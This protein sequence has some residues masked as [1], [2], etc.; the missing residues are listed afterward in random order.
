MTTRFS[1]GAGG[2]G[3]EMISDVDDLVVDWNVWV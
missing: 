3:G 2:A 1:C